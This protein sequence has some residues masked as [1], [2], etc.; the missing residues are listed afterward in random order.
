MADISI[1][2]ISHG[3]SDLVGRLLQD[4]ERHCN[5]TSLEVILTLNVPELLSFETSGF[6]FP[7]H[8]IRNETRKGFGENHNAAFSQAAAKYFCVMNPDIRIQDDP[9]PALITQLSISGIGVVAPRILN[10]QGLREDN[11]RDLPSPIEIIRKLLGGISAMHREEES[12]ISEP[13]WL[14]GMFLLFRR[15]TYAAIGGFDE[16]YF[17]YYEDVDL[18]TRLGL[19]GYR[20]TLCQRATAIHDAR[21]SSHRSLAYMRHHLVS[22]M[23][24]FLSDVYRRASRR[25]R[26]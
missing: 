26:S 6:T 19:A 4:I 21:R 20:V 23:R 14:A 18:C 3:Q 25:K 7:L 15:E 22:M 9:F 11:A 5:G 12:E 13:D 8:V 1:S 16:R 10:G 2:I 17:L 24:F